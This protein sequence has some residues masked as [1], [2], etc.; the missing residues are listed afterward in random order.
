M[1]FLATV[2]LFVLRPFESHRRQ[3]TPRELQSAL[4]RIS[5]RSLEDSE[6]AV[7]ML[8]AI[9]VIGTGLAIFFQPLG[10]RPRS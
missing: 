8:I 4:K 1:G 5:E 7:T 9:V 6:D 3:Q 10:T 2:A